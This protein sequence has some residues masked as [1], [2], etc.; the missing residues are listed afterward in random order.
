MLTSQ[1]VSPDFRQLLEYKA[2]E[3]DNDKFSSAI[4]KIKQEVTKLKPFVK[5]SD[6][7]ESEPK[8]SKPVM[9]DSIFATFSSN[10]SGENKIESETNSSNKPKG[11]SF[12]KKGKE[13]KTVVDSLDLFP[14]TTEMEN[15]PIEVDSLFEPEKKKAFE[16]VKK[17]ND[18]SS[19]EGSKQGSKVDDML[20]IFENKNQVEDEP[21]G[22]F[23]FVNK[24]QEKE[25]A[26]AK[27][28]FSFV[29]KET[30][31]PSEST[32]QEEKSKKFGF[33][34]KPEG[35]SEPKKKFGFVGQSS[36]E[37]TDINDI[38]SS[39]NNEFDSMFDSKVE[40]K[41]DIK[42]VEEEYYQSYNAKPIGKPDLTNFAFI[43]E[44]MAY[45]SA[46]S[47][48]H[49]MQEEKKEDKFADLAKMVM[50]RKH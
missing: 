47:P 40:S 5:K 9:D 26:P 25:N 2:N 7:F 49:N 11:F 20:D 19:V 18:T 13:D 44:G 43:Q 6:I 30:T 38:F 12:V 29:N 1:V 4:N 16:F 37:Q 32:I 27:G 17:K 14:S 21:Q 46:Y 28:K 34:K 15:K 48:S 50:N 22:K 39:G 36:Q 23:S 31:V 24:K 41:I 35:N 33:V 45:E 10:P 42:K 8:I 3:F